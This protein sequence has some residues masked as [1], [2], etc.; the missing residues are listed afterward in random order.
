MRRRRTLS[1]IA[2]GFGRSVRALLAEEDGRLPLTRAI[3]IVASEAGYTWAEARRALLHVGTREWHH[4]GLYGR[5]TLYYDLKAA[6][7]HVKAAQPDRPGS[8]PQSAGT[9]S[10]RSQS[11][12]DPSDG[13]RATELLLP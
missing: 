11:H 9:E 6:I 8:P 1:Y 4:T 2:H 5:R 10:Q 7:E 3:P 13:Q 12:Q